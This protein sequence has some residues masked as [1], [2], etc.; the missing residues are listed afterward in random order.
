VIQNAC[1]SHGSTKSIH[2]QAATC[3]GIMGIRINDATGFE[4]EPIS[5]HSHIT[6]DERTIEPALALR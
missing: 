1:R 2:R 6:E 4:P 3:A 5:S